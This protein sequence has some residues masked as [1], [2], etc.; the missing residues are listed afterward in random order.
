MKKLTALC[1]AITVAC[2]IS[3]CKNE[4]I[5]IEVSGLTISPSKVTA[6]ELEVGKTMQFSAGVLPA[7]ATQNVELVWTSSAPSVASVTQTGVVEALSNGD[8]AITVAVK[9]NESVN[10]SV[11]IAARTS[12]NMSIVFEDNVFAALVGDFDTNNDGKLQRGEA[13][14]VTELIISAKEINSLGELKYFTALEVLDFSNNYVSEVDL[15]ANTK[16]RELYCG[17]NRLEELDVTMLPDLEVLNCRS[18]RLQNIDVT[19]N[20]NLKVFKCGMNAGITEVDVTENPLLEDL[21]VYYLN[22]STLDVTHNPKLKWLDMGYCCHTN[23]SATPVE[24]LDLSNNPD[25]E[26][27]NCVSSN[28]P[29]FG[30]DELDVT[31]NPKLKR[32]FTYGNPKITELDLS[33]NSELRN[34]NV[35]HNSLSELDV[36]A[37]PLLDTLSCEW[38]LLSELDL[39]RSESLKYLNCANNNIGALDF[40]NTELGYLLAQNND[41]T[42]LV[43]GKV[44]ATIHP[45]DGGSSQSSVSNQPYLYMKISNN[46]LSGVLDLSD[47]VN[48]HWL[49]VDNNLLSGLSVRGCAKLGGLYCSNNSLETLDISGC[50]RLWELR[51][52][53]N[54]LTGTLDISECQGAFGNGISRLAAQENELVNIKVPADFDPDATYFLGGVGTLPCYTKDPETEWWYAE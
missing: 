34:L 29:G 51:C 4:K 17:S 32:L 14:A 3:G 25:L 31:H 9:G 28:Y 53:N 11:K 7:N 19:Q 18:N 50:T 49:E 16:L 20:P 43:M 33:H 36:T 42:S 22:I 8:A 38:N 1:L 44:F 21:D 13:A 6:F 48:L 27:L 46:K 39:S 5:G 37:C 12:E 41:L 26:Y 52:D 40:S 10:A 54:L 24:R 2:L 30:L 45:A 15:S 23:W 35:S 47:Q